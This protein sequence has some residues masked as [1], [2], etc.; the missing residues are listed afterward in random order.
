[1]TVLSDERLLE[2][3]NSNQCTSD[4]L[5]LLRAV[6]DAAVDADRAGRGEPFCYASVNKQGDVTS[7]VM[8]KDGWRNIPLYTHPHHTEDNLEMV[9]P[10]KLKHTPATL[11]EYD[12]GYIE[13]WNACR[14][15]LLATQ[16]EP[17]L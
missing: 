1:M 6:A 7:V 4:D 17:H 8:R 10:E 12:T 3:W 11:T 13:G 16:K 9:V 5:P 14:A 2:L 15:A